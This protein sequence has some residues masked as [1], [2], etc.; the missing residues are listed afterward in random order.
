LIFVGY[1]SG[2]DP[3]QG[4]DP[5]LKNYKKPE[6]CDSYKKFGNQLQNISFYDSKTDFKAPEKALAVWEERPAL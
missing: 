3:V 6:K 1:G 5:V 2:S 4:P